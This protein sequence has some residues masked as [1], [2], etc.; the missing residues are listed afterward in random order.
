MSAPQQ[1]VLM[2]PHNFEAEQSVLGAV[3][4]ASHH[5]DSDRVTNVLRMLKPDSFY[6]SIHGTIFNAMR[7]LAGRN[8]PLDLVT[9]DSYLTNRGESERVG[10]FSYLIELQKVMPSSANAVSYAMI[11]REHAARRFALRKLADA[12]ELLTERTGERLEGQMAAVQG[13]LSEIHEYTRTGKTSG[14]R[15]I[16]ET[17]EAWVEEISQRMEDP[18]A[19]AGYT[20]GI[21]GL[22]DLLYPKMLRR[23]SLVVVGARPK[24]GKTAFLLRIMIHFACEHQKPVG[25][26]SLEMPTMELWERMVSQEA[27]V[28][29]NKFYTGMDD[30]DF[31]KVEMAMSRMINTNLFVDDTPGITLSHLQAEARKLK[32]REGS[33]GC[34]AVDYLTLMKAEKAD[35]NDL[36]YGMITKGLKDLA[37][38]LDCP[39][40]LLTQLNRGLEQRQDK[41]PMPS[42]SRDTGQIEQDCDLWIGLYRDSVYNEEAPL[43]GATEA[44]VRLN[45]H[46]KSGTSYMN[47]V[48]GAFYDLD[49]SQI[50]RLLTDKSS[51]DN[52]GDDEF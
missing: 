9:L 38:E 13:L 26:F 21:Q 5:G 35:R 27:K 42:D 29:S 48:D 1:Q 28:N 16:R 34:I 23:G 12:T 24:M 50:G 7:D 14:L 15:H 44:I 4:Q 6:S 47:M 32:A 41:R 20:S 3:M 31:G 52:G 43:P 30:A 2:A 22:D 46:G 37:K 33:V 18:K 49:Q 19:N 51:R 11:V 17:A 40:F 8:Q 39:V 10:G 45:R 25:M 36:A